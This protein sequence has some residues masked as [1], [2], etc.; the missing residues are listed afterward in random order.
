[1]AYSPDVLVTALQE[2]LPGYSETFT[3]YHPLFDAIVLRGNKEKAKHPYKEFGLTPEGPGTLNSIIDGD[4]FLNGGRRQSSVRANT[5]AATFIYAYDVPGQDLRDAS[6]EADV[7]NLI[8]SYPERSL[9]DFHEII[10]RQIAMGNGPGA[11]QFFTFNGD[12]QYNPKGLGARQGMLEYAAP[13]A[14]VTNCFGVVK[15]SIVGWHNQYRHITAMGGDGHRQMRGAYWDASQQAAKPEGDVDLMFG[16]RESFDLYIDELTDYVQFVN[17]NGDV[18]KGDPGALP[19]R[20]G[21]RFLNAIFYPEQYIDIANMV[22]PE[23]IL[24]VIYGIHSAHMHCYTAGTS[25]KETNGDFAHRG[26]IRLPHQDMWRYEYVLS[27]GL[28]CKQLRCQFA[29][30]GGAQ[31]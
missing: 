24:G 11:G 31:P 3:M 7:V 21:V 6:G 25:E 5:Y 15:N 9:M 14:Q 2:L 19:L 4:E 22:T 20:E 12:A 8:K 17:R 30:T 27:M 23:A 10:A 13:A 18:K 26:P 28:Y 16:D 29:V 1:M